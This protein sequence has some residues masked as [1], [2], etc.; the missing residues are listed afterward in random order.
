MGAGWVSV[1]WWFQT[2]VLPRF[3]AYVP[4]LSPSCLSMRWSPICYARNECTQLLKTLS[5]VSK[6]SNPVAFRLVYGPLP[7]RRQCTYVHR[8]HFWSFLTLL[9]IFDSREASYTYYTDTHNRARNSYHTVCNHPSPEDPSLKR[10]K[11]S[12]SCGPTMTGPGPDYRLYTSFYDDKVV[13]K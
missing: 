4:S 10:Q 1:R 12:H 13:T 8:H 7:P 3:P 6:S 2:L 9:L 5:L 11:W